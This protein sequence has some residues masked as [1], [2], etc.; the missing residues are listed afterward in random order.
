M[1]NQ[2][3]EKHALDCETKIFT[4]KRNVPNDAIYEELKSLI[5]SSFSGVFL[6][7]LFD[8]GSLRF[9]LEGEG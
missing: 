5:S 8:L 4:R 7:H 3:T 2:V 9:V 6:F 1:M